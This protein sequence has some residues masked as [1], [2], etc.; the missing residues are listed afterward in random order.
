MSS[1]FADFMTYNDTFLSKEMLQHTRSKN[2]RYQ[3]SIS[4]VTES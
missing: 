3:H 4:R 2:Q 1:E